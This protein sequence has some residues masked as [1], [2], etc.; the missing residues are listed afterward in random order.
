MRAVAGWPAIE[1]CRRSPAKLRFCSKKC[2]CLPEVNYSNYKDR[3]EE[4]FLAP[5]HLRIHENRNRRLPL[6]SRLP[7]RL[8]NHQP[9]HRWTPDPRAKIDREIRRRRYQCGRAGTACRRSRRH[10]RRRTFRSRKKSK[11]AADAAST[12]LGLLPHSIR[13]R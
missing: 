5:N 3:P 13:A 6:E 7:A 1:I 12:L 2:P 10:P 4:G 11:F 9:N 8:L